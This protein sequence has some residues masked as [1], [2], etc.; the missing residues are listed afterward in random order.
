MSTAN[1]KR[2]LLETRIREVISAIGDDPNRKGLKDTPDRVIN[3]WRELFS[4]YDYAESDVPEILKTFETDDFEYDEMVVLKDCEFCSTC[5]HHMLPFTGVAHVAYI[6]SGRIV[7]GLSKLARLVDVYA[8]RLQVQERI[9]D[10]V[11]NALHKHLKP[12]GAA[13]VL[14]AHH[15][16]LVCRGARKQ[17]ATMITS[18][19]RGAFRDDASTRAEFLKLIG[20]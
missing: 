1:L 18:S 2:A 10:Q 4:G 19:L 9:T 14:E 17:T 3:S 13:C 15:M 8:R 5:E 6:P 7:V 16:C 20:G 11:C 12:L